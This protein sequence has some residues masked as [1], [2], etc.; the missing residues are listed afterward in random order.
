MDTLEK[1]VDIAWGL[2]ITGM[3]AI[4]LTVGDK[5]AAL[6]S[7]ATLYWFTQY[8]IHAYPKPK[9][10]ITTTIKG[11]DLV[12]CFNQGLCS[13]RKATRLKQDPSPSDSLSQERV[14]NTA[15]APKKTTNMSALEEFNHPERLG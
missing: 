2:F 14:T 1:A 9:K 12:V 7:A 6:L 10:E 4:F 5:T 13:S 8:F 11:R 15:T 3:L